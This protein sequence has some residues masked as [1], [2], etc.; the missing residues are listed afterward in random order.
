VIW[1][2]DTFA[3]L[4]R[5]L[6]IRTVSTDPVFISA[7]IYVIFAFIIVTFFLY[8]GIKILRITGIRSKSSQTK[9]VS[10]VFQIPFFS[11]VKLTIIIVATASLIAIQLLAMLLYFLPSGNVNT[12]TTLFI[13]WLWWTGIYG[14][15]LT[16]VIMFETVRKYYFSC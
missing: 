7:V 15:S 5:G 11:D 9:R 1:A 2:L 10:K 8:T 6:V 14:V 13:F 4:S 3:N 12:P 16:K